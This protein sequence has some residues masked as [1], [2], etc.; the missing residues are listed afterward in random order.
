MRRALWL[1]LALVL[2][3]ALGCGKAHGAKDDV[4]L[5]N[6][7]ILGDLFAQHEDAYGFGKGPHATLSGAQT[8]IAFRLENWVKEGQE[9]V[10]V[11]PRDERA[12]VRM[13][14]VGIELNDPTT[15]ESLTSYAVRDFAAYP[16]PAAGRENEILAV[17]WNGADANVTPHGDLHVVFA[18]GSVRAIDADTIGPTSDDPMLQKVRFYPR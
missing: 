11:C 2:S 12:V 4:C 7:E 3:S 10:L 13:G 18:D 17:C 6:L 8:V 5:R 1:A 9:L 15:W 14:A 16:V